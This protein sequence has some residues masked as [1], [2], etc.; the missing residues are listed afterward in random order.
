MKKK[1]KFVTI[2]VFML[3]LVFTLS[4]WRSQDK[5]PVNL[6]EANPPDPISQKA[7]PVETGKNFPATAAVIQGLS[8]K[9]RPDQQQQGG[10]AA[11]HRE[12]VLGAAPYSP[13]RLGW[14]LRPPA[15]RRWQRSEAQWPRARPDRHTNVNKGTL[16]TQLRAVLAEA[17]ITPLDP[18][19]EP[20]P[21]KVSLGRV[22]FFDKE[23]SGNRDISCATCHHPFLGSGDSLSVSIGTGAIGL[24]PIR[25]R[26]VGR[27]FIPRNAPEIFNR[28]SPDWFS[29]FWDSRITGTPET[30]F[31]TPAKELL[32]QGLE[33]ILAAQ[34]MF[35]V[36]SHDE[37]RGAVG[38]VDILGRPN[39][40]A[41]ID[42]TDFPA[43]WAAL[44]KRLLAIPEYVTLFRQAY[45]EVQLNQLGFHHAAN[46]IA[47]FEID[48]FTLL[49]SP[50][51]RYVAG[52]SSVLSDEEK[53]G[54]LLFYGK[55]DCARC[56]AGNLFTD[57]QHHNLTVPQL[58][59]GK[60]EEA[61]LDFGRGRETKDPVDRFK[62][63][64]PPLR[65]VVITG[66]WMH[67]GAYTHLR[68]A[69]E[70]HLDCEQAL[71]TY[72]VIQIDSELQQTLQISEETHAAVLKT[73]DPELAAPMILS[74]EEVDQLLAFLG[75]LTS[76][77]AVYLPQ[78]IPR[79]VP[80]GLPVAD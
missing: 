62:F 80:S 60:R 38:D 47:A 61:P 5:G 7:S 48:A 45:P 13:H 29:M 37:M 49:D 65:N 4:G 25:S 75:S 39:E 67:N 6:W 28:G 76:P 73:L 21:A 32:P 63:R 31:A 66:P 35:P 44:M 58:G 56:H 69:V 18:G 1:W 46:A 22:L 68:A 15:R 64:T 24:G 51:D 11:C 50:W 42:D 57:Q 40:L 30:G 70:H 17:G 54:A 77:S 78:A 10:C 2:I 43:T 14:G 74:D 34:A 36:T 41:I 33:S 12:P 26:G 53:R 8:A 3:L 79:T 23:L 71:L 52:D 59:P 55:A 9:L 20:D 72:D 27:E 16:D 19:P